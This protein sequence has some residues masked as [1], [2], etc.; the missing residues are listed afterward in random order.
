MLGTLGRSFTNW[1]QELGKHKFVWAN[2]VGKDK[3]RWIMDLLLSEKVKKDEADKLNLVLS[4]LDW[5]SKDVD[6]KARLI[7]NVLG[8]NDTVGNQ[9][10]SGML[11]D[12][13]GLHR[14]EHKE[15]VTWTLDLI[16]WS[17]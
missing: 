9:K 10:V 13:A 5:R 15:I 16:G 17:I 8:W 12:L 4:L 7:L 14:K 1:R 6:E 11:L 2:T 3:V